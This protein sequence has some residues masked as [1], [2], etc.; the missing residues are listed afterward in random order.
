MPRHN[1][2]RKRQSSSKTSY[3]YTFGHANY[4]SGIT[5]AST[6]RLVL[7]QFELESCVCCQ[8]LHEGQASMSSEPLPRSLYDGEQ[9]DCG[10]AKKNGPDPERVGLCL[11]HASNRSNETKRC[12]VYLSVTLTTSCSFVSAPPAVM[13]RRVVFIKEILRRCEA[14]SSR[15]SRLPK[16]MTVVEP[17]KETGRTNTKDIL[18]K[19]RSKLRLMGES[20]EARLQGTGA[21]GDQ[22]PPHLE[23]KRCQAGMHTYTET[24]EVS[25]VYSIHIDG[26]PPCRQ[27]VH[28]FRSRPVRKATRRRR[29]LGSVPAQAS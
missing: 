22:V 1:S 28:I 8:K 29:L 11:A 10:G 21:D 12:P 20:G 14:L 27:Y 6:R 13:I 5:S 9:R 3:T 24:I 26:H 19:K 2:Q 17:D 4:C 23:V 18:L 15:I 25:E 16:M 7:A